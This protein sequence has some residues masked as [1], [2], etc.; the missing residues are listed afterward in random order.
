MNQT[1]RQAT[2]LARARDQGHVTVEDLAREMAVATQTVRRDLNM[3]CEQGALMRVHG[4]A[5][6][7]SGVANLAYET[8]RAMASDAKAAIGRE[9][10]SLIP[11]GSTLFINIGTTTEAV[12]R[13]LA[14]H[15]RLRVMTNNLNVASILASHADCAVTVLGGDLRSTDNGL[16]G[17]LTQEAV[18][19]YKADFAIIGASAI[20]RDGELL[21]FDSSEIGISRT[22]LS[23]ART[24]IA[25]ADAEKFTRTAPVRICS[26]NQLDHFVTD[27]TPPDEVVCQL[28]SSATKLTC[29]ML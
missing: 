9:C 26:L 17:P 7:P 18:L 13:A 15:R 29:T 20:D 11:D 22:M 21:D 1:L 23:R 28:E 27:S 6:L 10:A 2:I 12:A 3:L 16:V 4:G 19:Q 24:T 25:V 5:V 14:Q 8:R